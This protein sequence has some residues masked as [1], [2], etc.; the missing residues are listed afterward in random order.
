MHFLAVRGVPRRLRRVLTSYSCVEGWAH[1]REEMMLDAGYRD[2]DDG[3]P[4]A[5]LLEALPRNV[6]LEVAIEMHTREM[7]VREAALR[8][9]EDAFLEP[10]P[11]E[12][13]AV[14]GTLDPGYLNYTL[15]KL[16]LQK[17]RDDVRTAEGA[18]FALRGF[19]DRLLSLGAPPIPLARRALLAH[20][21]AAL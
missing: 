12:K 4:V 15:G 17:L 1:Y 21:G 19:H 6:R 8:F 14:R 10:L 7:T 3:L 13:E 16:M 18:G 2:G 11:A 9:V 20:P 5:Q